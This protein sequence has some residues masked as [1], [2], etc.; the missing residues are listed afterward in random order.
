MLYLANDG[1]R[2]RTPARNVLEEFG[3]VLDAV[4]TAMRDEQHGRLHRAAPDTAAALKSCTN[5][6]RSFTFSTGVCG[7]MPWPR[8]KMWPGRASARR[9]ICSARLFTSRQDANSVI[10]SRFPCTAC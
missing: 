2:E 7:R 8:L 4:G 9:R 10:G 3:N 5:L 6:A 1:F